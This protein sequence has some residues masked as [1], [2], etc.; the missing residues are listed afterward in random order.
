MKYNI[1]INGFGRIGRLT[2]RAFLERKISDFNIVAV[3]DLGDINSNLHLL[4]YDSVHGI[5]PDEFTKNGEVLEIDES[6][7]HFLSEPN[8]KNLPWK[9]L[10]IDLVIESTGI[11][12]DRDKAQLHIESGAKKVLISAPSKNPDIT[13]VYG[14]NHNE[15]NDNFKIISNG[16]CTTNC[17]APIAYLMDK[18]LGIESGYMTTVH[19][20]TGDQ[21]T[22]DTIHKDLRRARNSLISIIPTSTG[23]A[24]AVGEVLPNLKGKIDGSAIRVPTANVSLVDFKFYAKK[25]TTQEELK[26]IFKEAELNDFKSVIET[27]DEPMVSGDFNHN[28]HSS[29]IDLSE[30]AVLENKF[31]RVL[32][33]YDNEWGF[34]NRLIDV[35]KKII[36]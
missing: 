6:K 23:A 4:K 2:L 16:S 34:S 5:L 27:V 22:I 19:S 25:E 31:C 17:L 32:S 21:N 12:T 15:I 29:I 8:P 33:W 35:I 28:P 13:V 14:I 30:L 9:S 26:S 18:N 3:N 20:V 7:I 24:R 11:F 10:N 1:A 36:E